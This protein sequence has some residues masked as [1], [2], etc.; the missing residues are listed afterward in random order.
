MPGLS[1]HCYNSCFLT[2]CSSW[3]FV[4]LTALVW[5][6]ATFRNFI[7]IGNSLSLKIVQLLSSCQ[8]RLNKKWRHCCSWGARFSARH[9]LFALRASPQRPALPRCSPFLSSSTR[10][11]WQASGLIGWAR[12]L[13]SR[14]K[15]SPQILCPTGMSTDRLTLTAVRESAALSPWLQHRPQVLASLPPQYLTSN[16]FPF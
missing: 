2:V 14:R 5:I 1:F 9:P 3:T 13:L 7:I 12:A 16:L 8:H 11:Q 6:F 15:L 10:M 4:S